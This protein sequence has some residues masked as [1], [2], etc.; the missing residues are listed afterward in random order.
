MPTTATIVGAG[1]NGLAAAIVLAN[2]GFAVD[3][4]EAASIPGGGARSGELTLPGFV[5]DLGSAVHPMA[6]ASPFFSSLPLA[7]AG[8][9]WIYPSA[10]LAHPLDDGT[11]VTLERT[12]DDTARQLGRDADA[13]RRLYK[14]LLDGWEGY[15]HDLLKP[16]GW[17]RHPMAMA[18]FGLLGLRSARAVAESHFQGIRARALFAGMAAH[19]FLPLESPLSAAFG[20]VLGMAGHT[21]GWPVPQGGAQSIADAL[22]TCLQNAGG[23]VTTNAPVLSLQSL[24]RPTVLDVTPRQML[25]LG[26]ERIPPSFR[27]RLRRYRYGPG[28]F[29]V[30]WALSQPIPWRAPECLRAAT[31][32]LGGTFDEIA[33]SERAPGKGIIARDPFVLLSQ[34]TLFDGTRAPAGNHIGW[35]YC[36]VPNGW[37]GSAL[38]AIESQVE[39]FA[40][41]FRDCILG[42][43]VF[44][45]E[46]MHAWNANLVGGDING[47]SFAGSQFFLRPTWRQYSTPL[48]GVY[49][50][51]SSTP[52][53][54]GVH[55]MC[56]YWAAQRVLKH[57]KPL[58]AS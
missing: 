17:P 53:G 57:H 20:L 46:E 22:V 27:R 40:P 23:K 54:G 25:A 36:H 47:G 21:V 11:A 34:P 2:A 4:R 52:P 15:R 7:E 33:T 6:V 51:S 19:S 37:S 24:E 16:I 58:Q 48:P 56:G 9:R 35:A 8:L 10:E 12:V 45:T 30:D 50:C 38:E 49:L 5:H 28:V 55:G 43:A 44:G 14:P 3:V 39:R 32:H 13:Y 18:R 31:V 29:K 42:R 41:G 1:P 26:G